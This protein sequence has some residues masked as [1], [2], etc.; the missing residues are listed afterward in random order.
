MS[1]T[2]YPIA[3]TITAAE[4]QRRAWNDILNGDHGLNFWAN[5]A[6]LHGKRMSIPEWGVTYRSDGHGGRD[7]PRFIT[8]MIA[9]IED[10]RNRVSYANYF[11]SPDSAKLAHDI[12][13]PDSR[14]PASAAEYLR[15]MRALS[16][17]W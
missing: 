8:N 5:F 13:R 2:H 17:V 10:P 9:F 1:W 16:L 4:A 12:R 6:R 7:N 3:G 15:Q 11:N 14:F